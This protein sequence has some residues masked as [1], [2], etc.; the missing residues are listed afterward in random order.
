VRAALDVLDAVQALG[1]ELG[2]PLA[3]RAGIVTGET[4]VTLGAQGE[5]MVAGDA[6]NTASRVQSLARSGTVLA[7][8]ATA[9]LAGGAIAFADEGA[10]ALK[11]KKVPEHLARAVRVRSGA[12]GARRSGGLEAPLTGRSAELRALK[13]LFHGCID[14]RTPHLVVLRGPA[15]AGKS[16]LGWEL[17]KYAGGL[18]ETVLWHRGRCLS[19]GE[20]VAYWA[21]AEIV[22]QR[23]GIGEEDPAAVAEAKLD[24]GLLRFFGHLLDWT[25]DLP[26]FVV[27]FARPGHEVLDA[28]YGAGRNRSTLSFEPLDDGSMRASSR[29]SSPACRKPSETP[30]PPAP[31][32]SR[33]SPSRRSTRWWTGA[34]S[35]V[36]PTEASSWPATSARWPSRRR[37]T[38]CWQRAST[39]FPTTR[40]GWRRP[41]ACSARTSRRRRSRR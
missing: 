20:G 3:A 13:E 30:S 37:S 39:R 23:F 10:H 7:D 6:V 8:D 38:A 27:L 17:E 11:G 40:G 33:S 22:R 5:G 4:A 9:K 35:P 31:R 41:P 19:Y 12:G 21:L 25:R 29:R 34:S 36:A 2:I 1:S 24:E 26:I 15:G 32:A 14:R 28:R 16:R 18:A